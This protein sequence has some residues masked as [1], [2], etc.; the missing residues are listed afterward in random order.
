MAISRD[1]LIKLGTAVKQGS[2]GKI[3]RLNKA[4]AG[5]AKFAAAAGLAMATAAAAGAVIWAVNAVKAAGK[6]QKATDFFEAGFKAYVSIQQ[7]ALEGRTKEIKAFANEIG[8]TQEEIFKLTGSAFDLLG[9]MG[10]I[11]EE[12]DNTAKALVGLA[13]DLA[14]GNPLIKD[15][16]QAMEALKKTMLGQT[17]AAKELFGIG[18]FGEQTKAGIKLF[19]ESMGKAATQTDILKIRLAILQ[20]GTKSLAGA[21]IRDGTD[22]DNVFGRF[23]AVLKN[24]QAT[25]GLVISKAILPYVDALSDLLGKNEEVITQNLA[26]F[27]LAIIEVLPTV[28]NLFIEVGVAVLNIVTVG[29]A[30]FDVVIVLIQGIGN[31]ATSFANLG[32]AAIEAAF[33][34]IVTVFD[35]IR[36][37]GT[38]AIGFVSG[39]FVSFVTVAIRPALVAVRILLSALSFVGI[40]GG[41]ARETLDAIFDSGR[42]SDA[43]KAL[44]NTQLSNDVIAKTDAAN[45]NLANVAAREGGNINKLA[46]RT[47]DFIGDT[48]STAFDELEARDKFR[49]K[50]Q[51]AISKFAD[52]VADGM[53]DAF[54]KTNDK[55]KSELIKTGNDMVN[56]VVKSQTEAREVINQ[57][58]AN[59]VAVGGI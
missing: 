11:G 32:L 14:S 43:A 56:K 12:L 16:S 21:A 33:W 13:E 52:S 25:V 9:P 41:E 15:A 18:D 19:E 48:V 22:I 45:R 8:V 29:T 40:I 57:T 54:D 2:V 58:M 49:M 6:L 50:T 55:A 44:Q 17:R 35:A 3:K 28:V 7:T 23:D 53:N 4:L 47:A 39:A 51:D 27:F 24:I 30:L 37:I 5:T 26:D 10:L 34:N 42:F 31:L 20:E 36:V 46:S 59:A 38:R 1:V